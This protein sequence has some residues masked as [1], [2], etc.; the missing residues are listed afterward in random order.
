VSIITTDQQGSIRMAFCNQVHFFV[1]RT[2][3]QPWL[4]G[5]PSMTVLPVAPTLT[6]SDNP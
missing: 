1:S 6:D 3:S 5:P 4:D 2:A